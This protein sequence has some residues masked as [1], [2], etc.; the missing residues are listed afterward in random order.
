M[1]KTGTFLDDLPAYVRDAYEIVGNQP[2]YALRNMIHAIDL[3]PSWEQ[4]GAEWVDAQERL[5]AA[6]LVLA[7]RR[8][9][10]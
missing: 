1:N 9:A 10:A 7:Y 5:D 2:T 3:I 6:K 4:T 8:R